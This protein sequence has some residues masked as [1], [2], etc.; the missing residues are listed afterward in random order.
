MIAELNALRQALTQEHDARMA[1][2]SG[3][4]LARARADLARQAV[5][6]EQLARELEAR[7]R[8]R[9]EAASGQ[10]PDAAQT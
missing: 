10:A 9:L 4:E 6:L 7:D 8:A 1:I 3:E 5:L 2:E